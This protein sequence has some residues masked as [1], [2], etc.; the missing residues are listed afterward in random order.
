MELTKIFVAHFAFLTFVL[1][2]APFCQLSLQLSTVGSAHS[3][4]NVLQLVYQSDQ[5]LHIEGWFA[6][7]SWTTNDGQLDT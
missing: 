2:G 1:A 5:F 4:E 6:D 7:S 3:S